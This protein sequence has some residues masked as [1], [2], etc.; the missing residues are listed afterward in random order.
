[1]YNT[2]SIPPS[3]LYGLMVIIIIGMKTNK[4]SLPPNISLSAWVIEHTKT[5]KYTL[6]IYAHI[7]PESTF[8]LCDAGRQGRCKCSVTVEIIG[9]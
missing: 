8:K 2:T 9:N 3:N 4:S 1:M 6:V 7:V 5:R